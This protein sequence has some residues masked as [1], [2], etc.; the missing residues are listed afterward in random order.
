M[1]RNVI[2][3]SKPLISPKAKRY[4]AECVDSGW[5]SSEGAFVD[6]FEKRFCEL[7]QIPFG[8]SVSSGT[9]GLD[10]IWEL[11]DLSSDDEVIVPSFTIISCVSHLIRLGVCV[12][13]ADCQSLTLNTEWSD[14]EKLITKKTKAILAVH[15]YGVPVD[16]VTIKSNCEQ[17]GITL[18]EDFSQ[19]IGQTI[20]GQQCGS[21]GDISVTSFYPN[22][23]ITTG[24]GG[25]ICAWD[26][27]VIQK[28]RSLKNLCFGSTNSTRFCHSALGFNYRMCNLQAALG[29]AQLEIVTEIVDQRVRRAHQY[30]RLLSGIDGIQLPVLNTGER[31]SNGFWAF[32]IR[33]PNSTGRDV[34]VMM[35]RLERASIGVRPLFMPLNLQPF[36]DQYGSCPIAEKEFDKGFYIPLY[37]SLDD[38]SQNYVVEQLTRL[39]IE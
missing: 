21:F 16:I 12:K 36:I 7:I 35:D 2:P 26:E 22:K 18:V 17:L 25:M 28:A 33:F 14:I 5:I 34:V 23:S 32:P 30:M 27:M 6:S 19:A 9:A 3:V 1:V 11:L 15:T 39:C 13:F 20:D 29:L 4:L 31:R 10:V 24:E 38:E 37:P 8:T